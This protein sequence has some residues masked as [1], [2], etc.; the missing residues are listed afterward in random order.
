MSDRNLEALNERVLIR[1]GVIGGDLLCNHLAV[2][3]VSKTA[4]PKADLVRVHLSLG[5]ATL[6]FLPAAALTKLVAADF[7]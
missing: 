5:A 2:F 1:K 4:C 7:R 6:V 3:P